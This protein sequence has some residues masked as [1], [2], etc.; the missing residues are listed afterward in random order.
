[1]LWCGGIFVVVVVVV[2]VVLLLYVL[3]LSAES[4]SGLHSV[5]QTE[6]VLLQMIFPVPHGKYFM[7]KYFYKARLAFSC[8]K[9]LSQSLQFD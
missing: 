8:E 3:L 6:E 5:L 2:V 1:M 7:I 4:A 9:F